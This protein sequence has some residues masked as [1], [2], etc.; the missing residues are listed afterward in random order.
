MWASSV[1]YSYGAEDQRLKQVSKQVARS[2]TPTLVLLIP[3]GTSRYLGT[4]GYRPPHGCLLGRGDTNCDTPF[5]HALSSLSALSASTGLPAGAAPAVK[6]QIPCTSPRQRL[7]SWDSIPTSKPWSYWFPCG[8]QVDSKIIWIL[9]L[10]WKSPDASVSQE[11]QLSWMLHDCHL[12]WMP[13][14]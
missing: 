6:H 9:D 13:S 1:Y 11:L 5:P 12:R 8:D 10:R 3:E 7:D 14:S 2:K 4:I